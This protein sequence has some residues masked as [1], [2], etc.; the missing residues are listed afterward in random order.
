MLERL[1]ASQFWSN[2][3]NR[4]DLIVVSMVV[5]ALAA[6]SETKLRLRPMHM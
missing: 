6:H 5:D 3:A 4:I 2:R 1:D